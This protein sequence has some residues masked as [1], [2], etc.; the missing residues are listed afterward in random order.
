MSLR[1]TAIVAALL[2]SAFLLPSASATDPVD[3][4]PLV[5]VCVDGV[6][7]PSCDD[8]AWICVGFSY[9]VPQCVEHQ[10]ILCDMP[11]DID[12]SGIPDPCETEYF[13]CVC[14]ICDEL[15]VEPTMLSGPEPMCMYYYY[16]LD[17]GIVRYV[18]RDSCHSEL[19]VNGE[20]VK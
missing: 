12:P 17:A 3:L 5:G 13:D 20:R 1:S 2:A 7:A 19:Y 10:A 14:Y 18:Q 6:T 8:D 16:E 11:C 15:P 9:Q 4:P